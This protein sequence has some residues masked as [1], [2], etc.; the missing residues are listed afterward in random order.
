VPVTLP[1]GR[2]LQFRGQVDRIDV[3][4]HGGIHVV[5]YKTGKSDDYKHISAER[6]DERGTHLQLV[7]YGAAA[8]H[9]RS[10]PDAEVR[11]EYW[12]V[13]TR[14]GYVYRGYTVDDDVRHK[15]A[16]T[17]G[18]IVAGIEAGV[19]PSHPA[20]QVSTSPFVACSACD[21]DAMGVV[22]HR[23][24]WETKRDDPALAVY[25][26]LADPLEDAELEI[27]EFDGD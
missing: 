17:L 15:V 5:D 14:G 7:V 6:P 23:R 4:E 9:A 19:F 8:C 10:D 26:N 24:A 16:D 25:V 27:E 12:F 1:D 2:T 22:E 18:T 21:P 11:A 3:D 13:T 20:D